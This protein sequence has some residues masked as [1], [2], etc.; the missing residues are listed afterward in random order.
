MLL[1]ERVT[2]GTSGHYMWTL[3][4]TRTASG[5]AAPCGSVSEPAPPSIPTRRG[6]E[7]EPQDGQAAR[8]PHEAAKPRSAVASNERHRP[9]I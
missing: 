7:V 5:R 2:P 8:R 9:S 6:L 3:A 1:S 4:G